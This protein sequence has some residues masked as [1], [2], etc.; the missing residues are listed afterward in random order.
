MSCVTSRQFAESTKTLVDRSSPNSS[1]GQP[2]DRHVD[3][4]GWAT[5]DLQLDAGAEVGEYVVEGL[6]GKG[7]FGAV[8]RAVQPMIG[9]LV[10]IKVLSL[11]YSADPEMASRFVSEARTVNRIG[12]EGIV[13]VFGFGELPDGRK[14]Y[15]MDALDGVTL[16]EHL[17]AQGRLG[18]GETLDI[19][20]G[21]GAALDAAHAADVAHRDLKPSNIFLVK[22]P[23]GYR[24]KL[25]DFGV[26]K[27]M[28]DEQPRAHRTETGA[29]LGTP[30]YMSPEQCKGRDV[31]HRSDIY[32]FGVLAFQLLTGKVPF[33][34][35]S[36]FAIM[37][38]H[39]FEPPPDP[40]EFVPE[41][42]EQFC[43][44]VLWLLEKAPDSRPPSLEVAM[45]AL[46]GARE[47]PPLSPPPERSGGAA[48]LGRGASPPAASAST[49]TVNQR[50]AVSTFETFGAAASQAELEVP[51]QTGLRSLGLGL[52]VS[53][54][55]LVGAA[56]VFVI[57]G[58]GGSASEEVA[59]SSA[60]RARR[61][62]GAEVQVMLTGLPA[63]ALVEDASGRRL[64]V[65]PGPVRL[66]RGEAPVELRFS[67]E[68]YEPGRR[69][70]VPDAD[71][72]MQINLRPRAA[73]AP[74][75]TPSP[76][77]E[78]VKTAPPPT[79]K[80]GMDDL[81]TWE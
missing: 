79:K 45:Q 9:K 54:L 15:V 70:V 19:L 17:L 43:R 10:A 8:Y 80:P 14:Y 35:S 29:A 50:P 21:V 46:R 1:S 67:A 42:P 69:R 39:V 32:A 6:L 34:S 40:R 28:D 13:G 78:P 53:A 62:V 2:R 64:R 49:R 65:G 66:P 47:V 58:I 11:K 41:L 77:P 18:V 36:V 23:E 61:V 22:T 76:A 3:D 51:K 30:A 63:D 25:L 73:V 16:S 48:G 24:P 7:A 57:G 44:A 20:A 60:P 27:L 33:D 59:S 52:G 72:A 56:S 4:D 75:P 55:V 71:G 31:D 81:E 5:G 38:G 26:A 74:T 12:H 37:N 68:G